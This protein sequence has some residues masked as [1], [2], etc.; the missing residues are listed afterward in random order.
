MRN[1]KKDLRL[2]LLWNIAVLGVFGWI[3]TTTAYHL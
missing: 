2:L 1:I 3:L